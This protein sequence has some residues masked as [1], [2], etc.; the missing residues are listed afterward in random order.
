MRSHFGRTRR[1]LARGE[2]LVPFTLSFA[3]EPL[4]ALLGKFSNCARGEGIPAGFVAHSTYWLIGDCDVVGVSNIRHCLTE[5]L[6]REGGNVGYGI[7]PS[8]RGHGLSHALLQGTLGQAR[9]LGLSEAWLTC[10]KTNIASIRT[11]MRNGG[12]LVSE[13]YLERRGEVVQRYRID[14]SSSSNAL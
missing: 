2:K 7:R 11:I 3:T 1:F 13:E 12:A 4:Q 6:R 10:A 5:A 14:L 9:L 8:G